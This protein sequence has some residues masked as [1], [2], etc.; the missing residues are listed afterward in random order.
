MRNFISFLVVLF[1]IAAFLRVDFYFTIAYLFFAV[2]VLS[3]LWL[4]H[5]VKGLQVKRNFVERAFCGDRVTV[6][7]LVREKSW[8]PLPWL[9]VD[10]LLPTQLISSP[11][12]TEV[13]S[14]G[15]RQ[16]QRLSYTLTCRQR[17]Y[18]PLGPLT[19]R[20]GDLLG[21]IRQ[22]PIHVEAERII[23][24]PRIVPISRLGLPT[25]SPLA[26][27][28]ARSPL[29][30]DP[31]RLMGV[32]DYQAGDSPRHIHWTASAGAGR[33]LVKRYQA[34]IARETLICLDLDEANYEGRRRYTAT[35]LA[36]VVA[37]SIA[38]HIVVHEKL[39][40]GLAIEAHDSVSDERAHFFLAPRSERAHLM[41]LLEILARVQVTTA[42]PFADMLRRE[43][44]RLSWGATLAVI[45]GK[46]GE[47]LFDS[48][49]YLKRAGFAVAL[50]L[51]DPPHDP[52]LTGIEKR[53]QAFAVPVHYV[54]READ[55]GV[56]S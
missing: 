16:Q 14:L 2:Y 22:P 19:L 6:E 40:V 26:A 21:A 38:N 1:L 52:R 29:F 46:A 47:E 9:Q 32:R 12:R 37:A 23:V 41:S 44:L 10:E 36:I 34:A 18:Y 43:S 50:I 35:E 45:T 54:W 55:T 56:W 53:G 5:A 7:L 30:Q 42:T 17:G 24:Y 39:P 33:L 49:V 51:V 20:T 11:F 25:H 8:L 28:P 48:L 13:I 4:T 3:R 15:P 27:L 31:T